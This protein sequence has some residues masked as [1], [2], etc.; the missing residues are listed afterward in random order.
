MLC[1]SDN[2]RWLRSKSDNKFVRLHSD[3]AKY[4]SFEMNWNDVVEIWE[5]VAA[6]TLLESTDNCLIAKTLNP[7]AQLQ[8]ISFHA[9]NI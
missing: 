7:G 1:F 2:L 4:P 9:I 5:F 8:T 3:N 6:I